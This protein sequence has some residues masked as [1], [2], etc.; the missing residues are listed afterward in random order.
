LRLGPSSQLQAA[1]AVAPGGATSVQAGQ[2]SPTGAGSPSC[3][4]MCMTKGGAGSTGGAGSVS[5]NG[6]APQAAHV[7]APEEFSSVH[8]GHGQPPAAAAGCC[9]CCGG[10]GG[11]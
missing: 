5:A 8:R 9:G 6:A 4:A 1:Q 2:V 10:G 3:T 11:G 7:V